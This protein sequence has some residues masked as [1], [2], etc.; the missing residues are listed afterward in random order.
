MSRRSTRCEPSEFVSL[1]PSYPTYKRHFLPR[2]AC[3]R[4]K[5][6][7]EL[8]PPPPLTKKCFY[9]PPTRIIID[10]PTCCYSCCG[11][12]RRYRK[13]PSQRKTRQVRFYDDYER[14]CTCFD[15]PTRRQCY[16]YRL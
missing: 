12:V 2:C 16:R 1:L 4:P 9:I 10:E 14:Q 15:R 3:C 11:S 7:I 8:P 5:P 13:Y 6:K